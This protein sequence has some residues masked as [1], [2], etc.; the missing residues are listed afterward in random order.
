MPPIDYLPAGLMLIV[1]LCCSAPAFAST[2]GEMTPQDA[3]RGSLWL[4]DD[5][6]G[7]YQPAPTVNTQVTMGIT[8][9][10]ARVQVRQSFTNPGQNWVEGVYVFPLPEHAAVDH[11]RML[12]GE[13][14]IEGQIKERQKAKK[15]YEKAK[16]AGKRA[17]LLEQERPNI[18]TTSLANIA[19]GESISVEIE[20]Q[21][22]VR[23]ADGVFRLRFPMVVGPRYIPGEPPRTEHSVSVFSATGWAQATT[24]VVDAPRITPPVRHPDKG[25]INPVN[26]NIELNAGIPLSS[27]TSSYHAIEQQQTNPGN[28]RI[29]LADGPQPAD[30]DFEL[31]WRPQP[32]SAPNAAWFT[33]Q[34]DQQHYGLLMLLPPQ[35]T[36]TPQHISRD[37][38]F[39]ID[40]S[41]SMHG[42][43]IAQARRALI[44]ALDRLG[45]QDRFNIIRF[46]QTA[47]KLFSRT[48]PATANNLAIA[49]RFV[50]RLHADG[51]TQMLPALKM[52]LQQQSESQGIRQ[53]IFLTD[54]SVGNEQ[55]LFQLIRQHLDNSRLFT[56]GIGSAPNSYFMRKAADY[57]RGTYTYIG[58][59]AEVMDR[60]SAL[61]TKLEQ[62]ALTDIQ[63]EPPPGTTIDI[64]PRRI[65]DLYSGEPLL[66][67][68]RSQAMPAWIKLQGRIG[69]QRWETRVTL[70]GGQQGKTLAP[71]WGRRQIS[72]L[73]T[74][75]H[76]ADN[77]NS[78]QALHDEIVNTALQH[79]LLSKYTSLVAVDVTPVRQSNE[80][81]Q[82]H[83]LK[84][85]LPKGWSYEHV[86]GMPQTATAAQLH[87]LVG[88]VLLVLASSG[89]YWL[90]KHP[91]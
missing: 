11:L 27:V 54:G 56:I 53:V 63:L 13:R 37:V 4:R 24:E 36:T 61:F 26:L 76:D 91:C 34:K 5:P 78:R 32:A 12:I 80:Q 52:A 82:Q 29:Q 90:R 9:M 30:R 44:L 46:N 77:E 68:L 39:V 45:T 71:E 23:Y 10:L 18:F 59:T 66:L 43:S 85:N 35:R 64:L 58:K 67:A 19:P 40:T 86:F 6:A 81:L 88:L 25:P 84:T 89:A 1:Q 50:G 79:H 20:Y 2:A 8:G 62:P 48:E 28:Y 74:R 55:R 87:L 16:Q 42:D 17:S 73:M 3:S 31:V 7:S 38:V 47:D 72:E 75:L 41:G 83:A 65:P 69:E 51:G 14:V 15:T 33:Q 49:R 70:N 22:T 57:G 21:Q 60:M